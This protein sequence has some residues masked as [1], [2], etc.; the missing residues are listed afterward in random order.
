[1]TD[2]TTD[3]T[4]GPT[5]P[6]IAETNG[7]VAYCYHGGRE[8][9]MAVIAWDSEGFALVADPDQMR[10]VRVEDWAA[11]AFP[12]ADE[13]DTWLETAAE[14][15]AEGWPEARNHHGNNNTE[16]G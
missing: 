12:S 5:G 1:M 4:R 13:R 14:A 16:V 6:V 11:S 8:S 15:A 7:T 3:D 10:L 2:N 9:R